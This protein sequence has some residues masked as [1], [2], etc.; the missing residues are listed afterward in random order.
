MIPRQP[1]KQSR[2]FL[3]NPAVIRLL[4]GAKIGDHVYVGTDGGGEDNGE[5]R[6]GSWGI[7]AGGVGNEIR[8][9]GATLPGY[10]QGIAAA[11]LWAVTL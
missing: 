10:D 1:N 3:P 4:N 8:G 5:D 11:E 7:A 9:L 2:T 6:V